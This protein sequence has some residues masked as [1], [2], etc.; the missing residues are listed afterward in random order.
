MDVKLRSQPSAGADRIDYLDAAKGV[1][2]LLIITEHHLQGAEDIV[3]YLYSMGVPSFFLITGFLYAYKREWEQ[4]FGTIAV[5]KMER[6]LYPYFT[7]SAINLLYNFLY[8]KVVFPSSVP[9]SSLGTMFVHTFTTYGYH[10]MWYLPC[11][12]WA[13]VVFIALRKCRHHAWI[14]AGLSVCLVVFYVLFD[15]RLSGLGFVSYLYCYL[16]RIAVAVVL[17]YAG[18]VLFFV[19]QKMNRP[20]ETLL[21]LVCTVISVVIAVLYQLYPEQFPVANIAVHRMGNPC[22]Y[23]LAAISA[24][25]AVMLICKRYSGRRGILTC[26]GRNSLILMALHMDVTVSIAWYIFA[27]LRFDF[28]ETINSLIVIG[29]ELLMFAVIIPIIHRFFPFI[30]APKKR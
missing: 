1:F 26:F 16:L 8:F 22:V 24:T 3:R 13:S 2:I 29:M 28:G 4:P 17:L 15:A 10:A 25:T 23:Y 6:L 11:M 21:L 19:F 7:F 5:R 14:W 9:E 27:K 18:A 30:L 20:Q 12:F